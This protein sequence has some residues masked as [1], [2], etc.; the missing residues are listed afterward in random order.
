MRDILADSCD[1]VKSSKERKTGLPPRTIAGPPPT[2]STTFRHCGV[3][4]SVTDRLVPAG[5][6]ADRN[7]ASLRATSTAPPGGIGWFPPWTTCVTVA[8]R[9][10]FG[11]AAGNEDRIASTAFGSGGVRGPHAGV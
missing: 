3:S 8:R 2:A 4:R 11:A 9:S 1:A 10:V 6:S 5:A 7:C